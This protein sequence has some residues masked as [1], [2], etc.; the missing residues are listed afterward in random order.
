MLEKFL[1]NKLKNK[2]KFLYVPGVIRKTKQVFETVFAFSEA[3]KGGFFTP[4]GKL[5]AT[6]SISGLRGGVA[7]HADVENGP[8][9]NFL[10]SFPQAKFRSGN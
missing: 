2:E 4:C 1:T 10:N 7:S 6:I 9:Q 5:V 3:K 8:Y